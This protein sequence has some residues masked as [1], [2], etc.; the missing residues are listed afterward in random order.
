MPR[1]TVVCPFSSL[2]AYEQ[3]VGNTRLLR[4]KAASDLTGC[5]IYGKAEYENPG[6]S[7]KDR[8]AL[9]MIKDAEKHG[10]L[11]RGKPGII[12]E[13]TAGN[14]GIGLA[15]A[16]GIFGYD[17]IIV[18]GSNQSQEKKDFLRWA[19]AELVEVPPAPF[20]NP[21]NFVHVAERIAANLSAQGCSNVFYANQWDNLANRRAHA[22]GTGPE[23]WEQTGGS[24]D[25]FSCAMGTGGTL[26]GCAE[27]LRSRTEKEVW[28]ML[29]R[30]LA[31][32]GA[33]SFKAVPRSGAINP[34]RFHVQ[35]CTNTPLT[36]PPHSLPF[37]ANPCFFPS[38]PSPFP[39]CC[40]P[41]LHASL[42]VKIMLTDPCG[43]VLHR[44]YT[45]GK[46]ERGEGDSI[47]EGIG[48]GRITGAIL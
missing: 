16:G 28:I 25:V 21:N 20:T 38:P 13:G 9:W 39:S 4:L 12:V 42:Q 29:S 30:T 37:S 44:Y 31:K 23:I 2:T 5:D 11:V 46:L 1:G 27:Y 35:P 18:L 45:E 3:S 41:Q 48:Q 7:V 17:V 14:T 10:H 26:T 32:S 36:I 15:L 33:I 8:A 47:S 40:Y 6:A 19:G 43:A 34:P 24:V 22:E